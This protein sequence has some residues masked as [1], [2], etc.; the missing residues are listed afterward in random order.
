MVLV[1]GLVIPLGLIGVFHDFKPEFSAP[2][3]VIDEPSIDE[4]NAAASAAVTYESGAGFVEALERAGVP[5]TNPTISPFTTSGAGM[6]F[7]VADNVSCKYPNGDVVMA[8]VAWPSEVSSTYF[9][10]YFEPYM[11]AKASSAPQALT[12]KG[13]LWFAWASNDQRLFDTQEAL[14]GQLIKP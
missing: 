1:I 10:M 14:G 11:E 2:V 7:H 13:E 3:T 6:T 12:L 8:F 5:C 4:R 9:S